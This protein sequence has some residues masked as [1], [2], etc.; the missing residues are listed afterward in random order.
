MLWF[1][2]NTSNCQINIWNQLMKTIKWHCPHT[3]SHLTKIKPP[4]LRLCLH[5]LEFHRR[6]QE[7]LWV[8]INLL[9]TLMLFNITPLPEIVPTHNYDIINTRKIYGPNWPKIV[10]IRIRDKDWLLVRIGMVRLYKIK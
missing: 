9:Q 7:K 8:H 4:K 6:L 1:M 2:K 5:H 3:I 10:F